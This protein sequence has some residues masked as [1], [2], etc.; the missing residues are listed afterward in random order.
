VDVTGLG[1]VFR[2]RAL[3]GLDLAGS[4]GGAGAW[5]EAAAVVPGALA[6]SSAPQREEPSYYRLTTGIDGSLGDRLYGFVEYHYNSAGAD[7]PGS[8]LDRFS[9]IAYTRGSAYLMGRHYAA[10][11]LSYEIHPLVPLTGL[12]L[13]NIA[14]GSA[15]F[16]PQAEYNIAE[17]IYLAAGALLKLGR[18]PALE[19]APGGRGFSTRLRSEFGAYPSFGFFAFRYYF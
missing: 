18:S 4:I 19:A 8:Y 16:F 10:A 13:W 9:M 5:L 14:D 7:A 11:G 17:N 3:F 6:P 15:A 12:F 2:E 1:L